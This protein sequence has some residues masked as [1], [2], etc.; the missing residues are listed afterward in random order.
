MAST[1]LSDTTVARVL[2]AHDPEERFLTT[3]VE[4]YQYEELLTQLGDNFR[5]RVTYLEGALEIMSPSR[6]HEL[7]K[8][9]ISRLLEAYFEEKRI[10]F[11][12]LGSTTFRRQEQRGGTEPDECYCLYADKDIPDL[13]IEVV[14]TSGSIDKLEV[15]KRLGITEVWFWRDMQCVVY[16]S[17]HGQY[18]MLPDSVLLPQLDL[19]L[20]SAYARQPDPLA[21]LLGY[22]ERLRQEA[23]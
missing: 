21:A 4:W 13:A 20:L 9:N 8:K 6:H 16:H 19:A 10:P 3:G 1:L 15:Y 5:Y 23:Q 17:R 11:W 18:E 14:V 12:G 2:G 22:R 7:R